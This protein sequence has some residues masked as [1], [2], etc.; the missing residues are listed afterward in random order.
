MLKDKLTEKAVLKNLS[1]HFNLSIP[2]KVFGNFKS[3]RNNNS[4][5]DFYT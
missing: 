5:L 3:V 2:S 1:V 4:L